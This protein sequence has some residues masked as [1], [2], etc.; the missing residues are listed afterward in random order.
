MRLTCRFFKDSGNLMNIK[1][2]IDFAFI[3]NNFENMLV[4]QSLFALPNIY[5]KTCRP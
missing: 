4:E 1:T 2:S 5:T 3:K